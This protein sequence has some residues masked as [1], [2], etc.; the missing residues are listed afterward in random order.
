MYLGLSIIG[1]VTTYIKVNKVYNLW[2]IF[3]KNFQVAYLLLIISTCINWDTLI[4][5]YNTT[6]AKTTDLSYLIQLSDNNTF[7]LKKYIETSQNKISIEDKHEVKAKY[8][9]YIEKLEDNDW[10]EFTFDNLKTY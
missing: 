5:Q 4:T 8:L 7:L 2:Y 1:L 9:D 10:Q 3:R 6:I